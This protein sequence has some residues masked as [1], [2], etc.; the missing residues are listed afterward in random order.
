M[1]IT[2]GLPIY[3]TADVDSIA[4]DK[5]GDN[6]ICVLRNPTTNRL[7]WVRYGLGLIGPQAGTIY[8]HAGTTGPAGTVICDNAQYS[9][10]SYPDAYAVCGSIYGAADPGMFRVPDLIG[11]T[12]RGH[13]GDM[14][15]GKPDSGR[16]FGSTQEV[17]MVIVGIAMSF[18]PVAVFG[19]LAHSLIQSGPQVLMG[20]GY[21]TI[22]FLLA[23]FCLYLFYVPGI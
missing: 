9:I 6:W 16:V 20:L 12:T 15:A 21:Y 4:Q 3:P 13:D 19:L 22:V 23:M 5:N 11:R 2:I 17:S 8:H 1:T 10:A 14:N 18:A 7:R